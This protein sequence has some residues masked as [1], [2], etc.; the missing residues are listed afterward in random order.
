MVA[1]RYLHERNHAWTSLCAH[2]HAG[3]QY[4]THVEPFHG[5]QESHKRVLV[6]WIY[7]GCSNVSVGLGESTA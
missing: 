1:F 6:F 4:E 5:S 7:A 2:T 3:H